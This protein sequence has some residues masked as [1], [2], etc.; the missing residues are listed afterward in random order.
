ML[1]QEKAKTIHASCLN[2]R[3]EGKYAKILIK[4]L[5]AQLVDIYIANPGKLEFIINYII[6]ACSQI[7]FVLN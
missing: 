6:F 2:F 1:S 5:P 7:C 4:H 3:F